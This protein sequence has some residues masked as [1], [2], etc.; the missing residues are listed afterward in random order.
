MTPARYRLL[1][2]GL[3]LAL[4]AVVVLAVAF[5]SPEGDAPDRPA[6]LE[7]IAPI[8]DER[9]LRQAV[10]E[11]D[12][13]TG[14]HA[15]IYVDG[16]R[17][18][19]NE[20]LGPEAID[21]TGTYRWRPSPTSTVLQEWAPGEHTVLVRWD[22][23]SGLPDPGEYR[24]ELPGDVSRRRVTADDITPRAPPGPSPASVRTAP[25]R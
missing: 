14:Y 23:V 10:L 21:A 15:E 12:L 1:L 19:D 20:F 11:V 4:V 3:G 7:R 2:G 5:G 24:M 16:F 22:T 8:P 6:A 13:P 25:R 18:P 9:V 17:I